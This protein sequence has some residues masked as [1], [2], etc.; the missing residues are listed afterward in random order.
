MSPPL[1]FVVA[2]APAAVP[3]PPAQSDFES[4][5]VPFVDDSPRN[6]RF[7]GVFQS[8]LSQDFY[9]RIVDRDLCQM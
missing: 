8:Q 9:R 4:P 3:T 2:A 5:L 6:L 1:V 7:A